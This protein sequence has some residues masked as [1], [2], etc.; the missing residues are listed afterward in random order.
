MRLNWFSKEKPSLIHIFQFIFESKSN[1]SFS[2]KKIK[3]VYNKFLFNLN[4]G[5]NRKMCLIVIL[6]NVFRFYN[7]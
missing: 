3:F 1:P 5:L 2:D 4:D 6:E 7:T